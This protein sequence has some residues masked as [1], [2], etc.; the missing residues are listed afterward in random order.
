M[1]PQIDRGNHGV[2]FKPAKDNMPDSFLIYGGINLG[3]FHSKVMLSS[4]L[5]RQHSQTALTTATCRSIKN[6]FY[7][8][9]GVF[10]H[11]SVNYGIFGYLR[12]GKSN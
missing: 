2:R 11:F 1:I 3:Q 4:G 5:E 10:S 6:H 7:C 9:T 8:Y 12:F